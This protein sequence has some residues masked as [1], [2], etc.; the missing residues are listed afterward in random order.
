MTS[1][2]K[3]YRPSALRLADTVRS[4]GLEDGLD[5]LLNLLYLRGVSGRRDA[6]LRWEDLRQDLGAS[7]DPQALL[8]DAMSERI[9][10]WEREGHR[11]ARSDGG[12]A[13]QGALNA[14]DALEPSDPLGPNIATTELFEAVLHHRSASLG[15]TA[16]EVETPVEV[17]RL[18]ARLVATDGL[19]ADQ[20]CGIGNTLMEAHRCGASRLSGTD[21]SRMAAARAFM[22]FDLAGIEADIRVG[23][24]LQEAQQLSDS[25]VLQPPFG[26]KLSTAQQQYLRG[27]DLILGSPGASNADAVWLQKTM[28]GLA[29][30]GHGAVLLPLGTLFK[31]GYDSHVRNS[32]LTAGCV[33][34]LVF[35]PEGLMASTQIPTC[36]WLLR[37][38]H[39]GA[40]NKVLFVD[41]STLTGRTRNRRHLTPEGI[42]TAV[43]IVET[44]RRTGVFPKEPYLAR[45]TPVSD[46]LEADGSLLPQSH[47]S[48]PPVTIAARPQP[49]ARLLTELRVGGFKSFGD[50]QRIPLAPIT[51]IYGPNSS[52]KS[53]LIQ[54]LLL[55]KQSIDAD[56]L[57]T[58]G[59]LVDAG[60]FVGALHRHDTT[61]TLTLGITYGALDE[62]QAPEGV[63]DP[64]LLRS[65]DVSFEADG[66]GQAHQGH[67]HYGF[68]NYELLLRRTSADDD[69]AAFE[70]QVD[71]MEAIFRGND[72]GT[73]LY[74]FHFQPG[75]AVEDRPEHVVGKGQRGATAGGRVAQQLRR[76]GI[77]TL[78]IEANGLL[79]G[80][81]AQ[82]ID[83]LTQ[84]Y[85][86]TRAPGRMQT[87]VRRGLALTSGMGY[88][89]RMLLEGMAYL[90]PMRS[91]PERFHNRTPSQRGAGSDGSHFAMYLFDNS[92]EVEKVNEWLARLG[93]PYALRVVPVGAIGSDH[94]VGDLVAV[95]L[96]DL[97]SGVEVSPADVGF[98]ISQVLPI[99]VEALARQRSVICVEQPEIHLHPALQAQLADLLIESTAEEGRANQFL[100]ETHS[101]HLVLRMQRR[102]REGSLSPDR[103][104][105]I[106]VNQDAHGTSRCSLLRLDKHGD[107]L[108][109]WPHGFF[110]E[111]LDEILGGWQ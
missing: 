63:P 15:R 44:W 103:V 111:R 37:P 90:G 25:L 31:A 87:V 70:A 14:L 86:H 34:A 36:L 48:S 58:Q 96:T 22:R 65:I 101:E 108:D 41:T 72:T 60:S 106:Y 42:D 110:E 46:L 39:A 77:N 81:S 79:A 76:V 50:E 32:L 61:G 59:A 104:N 78:S 20:A 100:V 43:N 95:I 40:G 52:G 102:I 16:G 19:V 1:S 9:P 91:A 53:S 88:E 11:S 68:G 105:V 18:M 97:R 2:E 6:S 107:F 26:V 55:L 64:A 51:L 94:V 5:L 92:S 54:G 69:A 4:L 30:G 38:P 3:E 8:D 49:S 82:T 27:R 17:A 33:E 62:W 66:L 83:I 47:L 56:T 67:A 75:L 12:K 85:A 73:L 21:V 10:F 99:V 45:A 84:R 23:D 29:E 93:V 74:P 7:A 89:V 98:G 71:D 109:Q 28:L 24:T 35:L 80:S 13:L 57:L